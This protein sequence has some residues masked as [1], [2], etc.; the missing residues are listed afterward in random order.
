[1]QQSACVCMHTN[2]FSDITVSA[3]VFVC[4]AK[5]VD[6]GHFRPAKPKVKAGRKSLQVMRSVHV[7]VHLR[8]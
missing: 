3:H 4:A 7:C 2:L 1:M 5:A 8:F 6:P